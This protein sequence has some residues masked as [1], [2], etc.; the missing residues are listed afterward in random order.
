MEALQDLLVDE[1]MT[2]E[3]KYDLVFHSTRCPFLHSIGIDDFDWYDPDCDY[4]DDV[5]AYINSFCN[6]YEN[7]CTETPKDLLDLYE[8]V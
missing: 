1:S 2:W 6:K 5:T 7:Y 4:V 8:E 3:N